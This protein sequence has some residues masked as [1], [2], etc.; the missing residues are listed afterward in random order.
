MLTELDNVKTTI[1]ISLGTKNRLRKL[2]G[3]LTYEDFINYIL[4]K[5][6]KNYA[7]IQS[8]ERKGA[9]IKIKNKTFPFKHNKYNESENFRFDIEPEN[10]REKTSNIKEEYESYFAMLAEAIKK[11]INPSFKHKGR[12]EDYYN[13]EKEFETL[14]LP[15]KAFEEDVLEKLLDYKQGEHLE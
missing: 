12:I 10:L 11:E 2:K 6:Q 1:T 5:K 4:R 7:E 14:G 9:T 15:R 3:S 13:W 8:L